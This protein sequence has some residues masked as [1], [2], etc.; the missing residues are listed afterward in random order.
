MKLP[1]AFHSRRVTEALS[2]LAVHVAAAYDIA[3]SLDPARTLR[4]ELKNDED[5]RVVLN[6]IESRHCRAGE[7]ITLV[8]ANLARIDEVWL[9]TDRLGGG[10]PQGYPLTR[11]G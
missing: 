1:Q 8:G 7:T 4:P 11:G 6:D 9:E 3:A 5:G 10:K 2:S